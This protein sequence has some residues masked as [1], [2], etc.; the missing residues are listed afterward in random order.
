MLLTPVRRRQRSP[1]PHSRLGQTGIRKWSGPD[2]ELRGGLCTPQSA[3][4][5]TRVRNL[6]LLPKPEARHASSGQPSRWRTARRRSL[7]LALGSPE[8]RAPT[9]TKLAGGRA[10][11]SLSGWPNPPWCG[12]GT[13]VA[14]GEAPRRPTATKTEWA[15]PGRANLHPFLVP[16]GLLPMLKTLPRQ[17]HTPGPRDW[18]RGR[19]LSPGSKPRGA[20]ESAHVGANRNGKHSVARKSLRDTHPERRK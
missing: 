12:Q 8:C 7:G 17:F 15:P 20:D 9:R 14:F 10:R 13:H 2:E 19:W 5:R 6:H 1:P 11:V 3:A 4:S 18:R 16:P